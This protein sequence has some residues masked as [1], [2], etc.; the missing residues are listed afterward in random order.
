MVAKGGAKF[1]VLT[2]R[3]KYI[4]NLYNEKLQLKLLK[5]N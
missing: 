2:T 4:K 3:L 5:K 1:K